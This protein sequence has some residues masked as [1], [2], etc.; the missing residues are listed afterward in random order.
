[1]HYHVIGSNAIG[2]GFFYSV[3]VLSVLSVL[4]DRISHF[5]RVSGPGLYC[6]LESTLS[7]F[8]R[9]FGPG[10]YRPL[11]SSRQY[12]FLCRHSRMPTFNLLAPMSVC[13]LRGV[14]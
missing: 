2:K 8:L 4:A 11:E 1:M 6:P 9:V 3:T 10:L 14:Y 5:L 13:A 12:Q 7:R